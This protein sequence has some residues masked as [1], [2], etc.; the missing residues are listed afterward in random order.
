MNPA[1]ALIVGH[2]IVY[3]ENGSAKRLQGLAIALH[4]IGK[5]IR[6]TLSLSR[7]SRSLS[8]ALCREIFHQHAMCKDVAVT[9]SPGFTLVLLK[10]LLR[11]TEGMNALE[12]LT[13]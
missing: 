10:E 2:R 4:P 8:V 3:S 13:M 6:V 7:Q 1:L 9:T 5:A 12:R 11:W